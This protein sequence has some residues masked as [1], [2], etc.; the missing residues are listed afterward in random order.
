MEAEAEIAPDRA[1]P[2]RRRRWGPVR[3]S[4]MAAVL[5]LGGMSA[6]AWWFTGCHDDWCAGST[7][8]LSVTLHTTPP[9]CWND[10]A[11][12]RPGGQLW[13]SRDHAPASWG[14]GP[15][16]GTFRV[17]DDGRHAFGQV[18]TPRT[19]VFTADQGG[20]VTFR[21]GTNHYFDDLECAIR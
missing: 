20:S 15:V 1:E 9:V 10:V 12:L 2:P 7:H 19:A 11:D 14:S 18:P 4:I 5:V 13:I 8:R 16:P 21:G 6:Y 17:T 3:F